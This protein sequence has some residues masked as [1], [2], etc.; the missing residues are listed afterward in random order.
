ML[1]YYL[2]NAYRINNQLDKAIE[3]YFLF[4][5]NLDSEVYDSNI[6]NLQIQSCLNAQELMSI[7]LFIK[8]TNLGDMINESRF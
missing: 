5:K 1:Y 7:P 2:A 8:E 6:V 4:K 3:T